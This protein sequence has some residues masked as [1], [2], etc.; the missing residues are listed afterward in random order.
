MDETNFADEVPAG[1]LGMSP[2]ALICVFPGEEQ[3]KVW[4][5]SEIDDDIPAKKVPM[6]MSF[7]EETK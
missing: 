4:V 6:M 7:R 1:Q 5:V 2:L 3:S